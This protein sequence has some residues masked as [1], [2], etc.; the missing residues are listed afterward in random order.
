MQASS[1]GRAT[2][3]AS[4][5][6]AS[7][8]SGPGTRR[9]QRSRCFGSCAARRLQCRSVEPELGP[10]PLVSVVTPSMNQGAFIEETIQS[11]LDQ[12]YPRIEHI[13]VDGGST[14][15]T[16]EVLRRFPSVRWISEGDEG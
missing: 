8:C 11:V 7:V 16:V 14:D 10:S 9:V 4:P 6:S 13:V 12:D 3:T 5:V 15:E 2:E 1:A